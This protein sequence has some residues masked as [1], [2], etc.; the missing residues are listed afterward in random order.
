MSHDG[1]CIG[2]RTGADVITLDR[3]NESFGHSVALRAFDWC[4]P[5]LQP[6]LPSKTA[7]LPG[8]ITTAII[9]QPFDRDRQPV[10]QTEAMLDRH[11][12]EVAHIT[13][14]DSAGRRKKAH[15]FTIAAIEGEGDPD[16]LAVVTADLEAVGA[17]AAVSLI[18]RDA[19]VVTS[20]G[21]TA[22]PIEQQAM[23]LHDPIDSFVVRRLTPLCQGPPLEDGMDTPIA[24]GRQLGNHRLDRRHQIAVPGLAAG[25]S[26]ASAALAHARSGWTALPRSPPPR[27]S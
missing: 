25:Q 8:G 3:A 4:R 6:D 5:R 9:R 20:L 21:A 24:V 14:G 22:V 1:G 13:T 15:G 26:A 2:T 17:P 19:A 16:L 18:H 10:D 23:D 12:H 27:S 11:Q 7:G